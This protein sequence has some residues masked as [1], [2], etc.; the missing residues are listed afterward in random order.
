[1]YLA[2]GVVICGR[3]FDLKMFDLCVFVFC[4]CAGLWGCGVGVMGQVGRVRVRI[5]DLESSHFHVGG[6][7][8]T[9]VRSLHSRLLLL[10]PMAAIFP[11]GLLYLLRA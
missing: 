10:P 11:E 7:F 6:M 4:V 9:I 5:V 8:S 2:V 3:G 1:V